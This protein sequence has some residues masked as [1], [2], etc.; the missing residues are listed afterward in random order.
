MPDEQADQLA[1]AW[2]ALAALS[3]EERQQV[4]AM[5]QQPMTS[6]RSGGVDVEAGRVNVTGDMTGRDKIIG[7]VY[8]GAPPRDTAEA[9]TIYRTVVASSCGQLPLRGVDVGASDATAAQKPLGLAN[10]Y[11]D[12]DTTARVALTPEEKKK[13]ERE[14]DAG[15]RGEGD[16]RPLGALEALIA[17]R[18]MVLLGDPGGG[19]ST[20]VNHLAL[21]LAMNALEPKAR[22]LEHLPNWPGADGEILPVVVILRDFARGLPESLPRATPNHLWNFIVDRL[23][24]QNLSFAAEP[25]E[26]ALEK[27]RALILLDGLDEVPTVKQRIFVRDAV[28]EFIRRYPKNR[29][30]ITCRVLSYQPPAKRDAPDLRLPPQVPSFELAAFDEDKINRFIA[31]WYSE[32]ARLGSVRDQQVA[33]ST[34]QLRQAVRRPDLWRLAKNPLLLTVMALVHTHKGRLPDARAMLYEETVDILLW[35]WEQ[36]K[37]EAPLRQL[38]LDANRAEVDLKRV[39]SQLAFEAHAQ[40]KADDDQEKLADIGESKLLHALAALNQ[41]DLNWAEEMID[42]MKFRAGLLLERAPEIFTFPHRTFQEYLAGAHLASQSNFARE[43]C[44]LAEQGPLWREAILMAVG[45]LVYLSRDTDKPLALV[46]ELC[47]AQA[48]DDAMSWRKAW[49]AG[50]ALLEMGVNRVTDG[51]LGRDLLARVQTRL[52][53]LLY[54]G[55]L[56]P[57][58]RASAGSTLARLG[59]PRPEVTTINSMQFCYVPPGA[60]VMGEGKGEEHTN[61]TLDYGYWISRYPITN[62]QYAV[63]VGAGGYGEADYWREA[64]AQGWWKAGRFKGR[65]DDEPHD[66]PYDFGEPFNLPNHPVVGVAWYEALAFTRWLTEQWREHGIL[67]PRWEVRLPS[68]AEWEKAARGGMEIPQRPVI[69]RLSSIARVPMQQN[70]TPRRA[71]PW[72]NK[73][74]PNCANY[75]ESRIEATNALGCFNAG[76]SPYGCEEMSGNVWEWTRSVHHSYPYHPKDGR[77]DLSSQ[78]HRVVRG[79]AF[80]FS[81]GYARCV[82]RFRNNPA[83]G[84]RNDGFRVVALPL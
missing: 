80:H 25:I 72:G 45:Y 38:L 84:G 51:A 31:A 56:S 35:R 61:K 23:K 71:F 10:V 29:F 3:P 67:A 58:E 11:V 14:A 21:C 30:L 82:F 2:Q 76:R 19:K 62:A 47:P 20:F 9:L 59:D 16:S 55:Q 73:A 12:L 4:L 83:L 39:L 5:L 70:D 69:G 75:D 52:T 46:G 49:L 43:A 77:E 7:N 41:D 78:D 32:L 17:N 63:F 24:D 8:Y 34:R 50:D 22:W 40:S 66:R 79:G 18:Q 53:D 74:D 13:R 36:V 60:F 15:L 33:D 37:Q 27:G 64:T 1:K 42:A 65:Y 68:E 81:E 44:Q 57:R 54:S 28:T 26:Q 48:R 6:S